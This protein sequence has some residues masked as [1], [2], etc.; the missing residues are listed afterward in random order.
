MRSV[1]LLLTLTLAVGC[2]LCGSGST[3]VEAPHPNSTAPPAVGQSQGGPSAAPAKPGTIPV[4]P[5]NTSIEF[6]GSTSLASHTGH[7]AGFDGTMELP[8]GTPTDM[9]IR[10]VVTMDSITTSIRLLTKHLKAEDFFDVARYPTAEFVS[11]SVSPA[12]EPGVY[13]VAGRLTLRGVT[14][15]IAFPARIAVTDGAVQFDG[16]MTVIQTHFGMTEAARKT[17]D[18]VPV[19]IS[20]HG[21]PT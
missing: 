12:A 6:T 20:V 21:R 18:E 11:E 4:N 2:H 15:P 19:T 17:K 7:F 1:A 16:T 8:T 13:Q 5:A 3:S 10:V 9:K 14:R